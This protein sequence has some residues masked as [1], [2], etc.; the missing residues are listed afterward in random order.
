MP[1]WKEQAHICIQASEVHSSLSKSTRVRAS[2]DV[3]IGQNAAS[4]FCTLH[5]FLCTRLQVVGRGAVWGE[6][7]YPLLHGG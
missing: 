7:G 3:C 4:H 6:C 1:G 2:T 5:S